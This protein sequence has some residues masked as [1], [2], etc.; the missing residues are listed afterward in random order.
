MGI[1]RTAAIVAVAITL[2]PSDP[3]DRAHLYAKAQDTVAWAT[4]FCDRNEKT[5]A[6]GAQ[7][8][9]AFLEKAAFAASSAYDIAL[10]QLT[11]D[12]DDS[13]LEEPTARAQSRQRAYGTLTSYDRQAAWRGHR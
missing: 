10:V 8:R 13:V 7:L 11:D 12:R 2:I 5:C 6:N 3:R 4:T 1:I 9:D